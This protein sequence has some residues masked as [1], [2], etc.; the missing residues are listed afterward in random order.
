MALIN[1]VPEQIGADIMLRLYMFP[2]ALP[3]SLQAEQDECFAREAK[4]EVFFREEVKQ[5]MS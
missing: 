2:D 3:N 4:L 1:I 5:L